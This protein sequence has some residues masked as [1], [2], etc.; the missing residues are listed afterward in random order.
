MPALVIQCE[1]FTFPTT[2]PQLHLP[3]FG[4]FRKLGT[5]IDSIPDG[6]QLIGE[7]L[8]DL[9]EQLAP[10]SA[11]LEIVEALMAVYTCLKELPENVMTLDFAAILECVQKVAKA[12]ALLFGYVPPMGYIRTA[13]D[14][15]GFS[16]DLI[17]EIFTLLRKVDNKITA[18][19]STY[20]EAKQLA[21]GDLQVMSECA[22][23][24]VA[25][26][27]DKIMQLIGFIKQ[28]NDPLIGMFKRL[29][30]GGDLKVSLKN[31][32]KQYDESTE[33]LEDV[34]SAV[35]DAGSWAGVEI[36]DY[37][38]MEFEV[39][40]IHEIVPVP[41]MEPVMAAINDIRGA[42]VII[43][44]GLAPLVG[45]EPNKSPVPDPVYRNF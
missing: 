35:S 24:E 31:A 21:D 23:D 30:P 36:P 37:L 4:V 45:V 29:L 44:N 13:V 32:Q 9:Q 12:I 33:Y 28:T 20:E 7:F 42:C 18:L 38:S 3:G 11:I 34:A 10:L 1:R 25:W 2:P 15:S 43:Y 22:A 41:Q 6:G 40:D 26:L 19:I 5:A 39:K 17:D 8:D 16:V 14:I 27:M